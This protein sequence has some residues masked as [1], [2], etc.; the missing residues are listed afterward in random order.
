MFDIG[1]GVSWVEAIALLKGLQI[2]DR[3]HLTTTMR[4]W[5]W[6]ARISEIATV[7]AIEAWMEMHREKGKGQKVTLPQPFG[8]VDVEAFTD[9][10]RAA[11]EAVLAENSVFSARD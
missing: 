8:D 4:G 10:E 3:S 11:A 1:V 7:A 5:K 2:E 6:P 9:A